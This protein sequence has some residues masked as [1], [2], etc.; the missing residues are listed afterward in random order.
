MFSFLYDVSL[1]V[2]ALLVLP[3]LLWQWFVLGKY[4]ESLSARLGIALPSFTPKEGQEVIW[5]HAVSMGETRAAISLF[6]M[7]RQAFPEAA[8][9][10]S[11]TTETGNAEAKRSM[12]DAD[13]HFFLPLDFSWSIR[14]I[15]DRIRPSTLI[16]CESDFWY[17]LLKTAK[18]RGVKIALVN[19]KVS[20]RSC[21]RF[22]KA[23]SFTRR[24]FSNFDIL[25]VQSERYRQRFISMGVPLEKLFATGNLKFDAPAQKM[26]PSE[27]QTLRETLKI[28]PDDPVLV[29]GST[30]AQEE[31]WLLS[32][33]DLV[34]K[35]NP[36]LKVLLVP[37]HPERFN[38]VAHLI[39]EKGLTC[40]RISEK[41]NSADR[42]VLVDAM[43]LLNQCYQIASVAVVGGSYVSHV[44]G[45]NIFE[46]VLYGVPVFFGPHMHS[47][48]DLQ[49]LILTAKAGREVN[50]EEL[51]AALIEILEVPAVHNQY[52]EAGRELAK[53]VQGA[54]LRTFEHIFSNEALL[55]SK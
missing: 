26:Q 3:K 16:L 10:I 40:R 44:G 22:R 11:T 13:A 53:S 41:R 19:G 36:R 42:L 37:R 47:Q 8:I 51:P 6:R 9:V 52:V 12:P 39:K 48:P 34:W 15:L 35:K 46:P 27:L 7:V 55:K 20:E 21:K 33:L 5:I 1:F 23:P 50:I 54:T 30:H 14:R 45:H 25:C 17:H 32:A 28:A 24:I 38:E 2:F 49:E 29:L 18:E 31:D 4:R 43:G